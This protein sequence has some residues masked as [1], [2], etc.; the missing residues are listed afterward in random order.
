VVADGL[1]AAVNRF[2]ENG[3]RLVVVLEDHSMPASL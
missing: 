3:D 1:L 2:F